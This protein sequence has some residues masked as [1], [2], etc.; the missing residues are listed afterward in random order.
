MGRHRVGGKRRLEVEGPVEHGLFHPEL[1]AETPEPLDRRPIVAEHVL[2]VDSHNQVRYL[3]RRLVD[4][5]QCAARRLDRLEVLRQRGEIPGTAVGD[6]QPGAF[7]GR[8]GSDDLR[9]SRDTGEGLQG[10]LLTLRPGR[11][12]VDLHDGCDRF[13]FLHPEY[14]VGS[15][16]Q[17][18]NPGVR[19]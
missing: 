8:P 14:R 12:R 7:A 6:S 10:V 3:R 4:T 1:A 9:N 5:P 19:I 13:G 11:D 16:G 15:C 18:P 17:L 2:G